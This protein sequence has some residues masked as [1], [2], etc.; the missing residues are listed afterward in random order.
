MPAIALPSADSTSA[1]IVP[2]DGAAWLEVHAGVSVGLGGPTVGVLPGP[3]NKATCNLLITNSDY[4]RYNPSVTRSRPDSVPCSFNQELSGH[5][6]Q[7]GDFKIRW[8][9]YLCGTFG[10]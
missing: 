6:G 4:S 3:V 10:G 8:T 7:L 1:R 5:D 9:E 2:R